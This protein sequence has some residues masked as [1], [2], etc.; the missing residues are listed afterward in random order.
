MKKEI[1]FEEAY[2]TILALLPSVHREDLLQISN[3]AN[4]ILSLR[5]IYDGDD[6]VT[7]HL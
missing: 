6:V 5:S 7:L 1:S 4:A 3:A 2:Q